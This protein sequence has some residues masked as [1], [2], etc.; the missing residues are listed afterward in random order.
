MPKF[1]NNRCRDRD[2]TLWMGKGKKKTKSNF[3]STMEKSR[4]WN[5]DI[6]MYIERGNVSFAGST[7]VGK[8]RLSYVSELH[9]FAIIHIGDGG[10]ALADEVVVVDVVRQQAI[11]YMGVDEKLFF[12]IF[13]RNFIWRMLEGGREIVTKQ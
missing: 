12:N 10:F 1:E 5:R 4:V 9:F 3:K 8:T 2:F 7:A 11:L 6:K 13:I